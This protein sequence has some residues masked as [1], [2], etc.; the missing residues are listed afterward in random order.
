MDE[1]M[2]PAVTGATVQIRIDHHS[3]VQVAAEAARTLAEQ[4]GLTGSLPDR[5]AV[6]ASELAGNVDKHATGGAVYL[7]PL[8]MGGGME[9][10]AVDRGPGIDDLPRALTDGYS[11]TATLGAGLGAIRRIATEVTIRT[12]PGTGTLV[13]ARLTGPDHRHRA[14]LDAGSA[15]LPIEG[16][17]LCGDACASADTAGSRTALVVD[18]LGHGPEA[19][20]AAQAALRVFR[21][22]PDRA[23]PDML[24]SVH[25]SLR[26]TRGAAVGI[27]RLHQGRAEYCGAGN[28][29]A[30]VVTHQGIRPWVTGRPGVVGWN[31]PTPQTHTL[32]TDQGAIA[33]LHSDGIN[34]RWALTPS[35]FLLRLPP[36][37]LPAAVA[38]THRSTRDDATVLAA[39][40]P[41][42]PFA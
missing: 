15:C 27:M 16:Q 17:Q 11:T 40:A 7:Q 34:P 18:G 31:M 39:R 35:P 38:H 30:S 9:I 10:V 26:H 13:C 36:S 2:T 24:T 4:C 29:R 19:S 12:E 3:A 28:I 23:L 25:R 6:L 14:R 20:E 1:S 21:R 37:L 42:G 32:P 41:G 5:A 22:A 8:L 33:V